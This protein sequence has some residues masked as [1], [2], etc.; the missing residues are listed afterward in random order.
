MIYTNII[1]LLC[2]ALD[3]TIQLERLS[4]IAQDGL[5]LP[6]ELN[7]GVQ[8][9]RIQLEKLVDGFRTID[10]DV[11]NPII[12]D[13]WLFRKVCDV[14][15]LHPE[16]ECLPSL[17]RKIIYQL[18]GHA[19]I[20]LETD[21]KDSL[22][23]VHISCR[24]RIEEAKESVRSFS[25]LGEDVRQIIV[26]ADQVTDEGGFY[27]RYDG[28]TMTL[29]CPDSYE[30][31]YKKCLNCFALLSMVSNPKLLFKVDDDIRLTDSRRFTYTLSQIANL[32]IMYA[33]VPISG[34]NNHRKFWHGWH[35]GKCTDKYYETMGY[36]APVPSQYADG[37]SGYWLGQ[38]S[39]QKL[40]Y[41]YFTQQAFLDVRSILFEDVLVGLFLEQSGIKLTDMCMES[42]LSSKGILMQED[43]GERYTQFISNKK[44]NIARLSGHPILY[45]QNEETFIR[46]EQGNYY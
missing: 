19:I 3:Y 31:H 23:I 5:T 14:W 1:N 10:M 32:N 9:Q 40:A 6:D 17:I 29:N 27:L 38:E 28:L 13:S 2:Q 24:L 43:F 36:Q 34:I 8:A 45:E 33:G 20:E 11:D 4:L 44:A 46:S 15:S 41:F 16:N 26:I 39:L 18:G 42:C 12:I 37:G 22:C 25:S 21:L 30:G 7:K 35:I